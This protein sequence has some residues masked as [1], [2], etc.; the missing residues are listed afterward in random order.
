M[1]N[2]TNEAVRPA[3][4]ETISTIPSRTD[5]VNT[6]A[7]AR[8]ASRE[9]KSKGYNNFAYAI[10]A[11]LNTTRFA[12]ETLNGD[13]LS[14]R[15]GYQAGALFRAGGRLYGQLGAEYFASSSNYFRAGDGTSVS[16]IQD[17]IN[18]QYLQ[19]PVYI[20]YKLVQS[21]R[22]I[23]AVRLQAGLE[24]ANRISANSRSFNLNKSEIKSGTV[25]GL[26]QLGFDMGPVLLDL[27]YHHGFA[28]AIQAV[29]SIGFAGS[30]RRVLSASLGWTF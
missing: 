22:G 17:Q 4:Q 3:P 26:A 24:Y 12:G 16:S 18:I 11:G 10:Y 27:T 14:G 29:N 8:P 1:V 7:S 2:H 25:N 30:Q 28:N 6:A 21:L 23:S 9:Q 20:G 13:Q 15:L 19:V 5:D